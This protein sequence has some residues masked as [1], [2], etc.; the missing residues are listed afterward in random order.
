VCASACQHTVTQREQGEGVEKRTLPVGQR[1]TRVG[2]H[3]P[4]IRRF[5]PIHCTS[6]SGP[7]GGRGWSGRTPR[8]PG[9]P[10]GCPAG[11]ACTRWAGGP[12]GQGCARGCTPTHARTHNHARTHA[13]PRAH[14]YAHARLCT[15]MHTHAYAHIGTHAHTRTHTHGMGHRVC[16]ENKECMCVCVRVCV[17]ERGR[18]HHTV[19]QYR[20]AVWRHAPDAVRQKCRPQVS[21]PA[22]PAGRPPQPRSRRR[23]EAWARARQRCRRSRNKHAHLLFP[24]TSDTHTILS[25]TIHTH[26]RTYM[27]R[28]KMSRGYKGTGVQGGARAD[29]EG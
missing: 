14:A 1:I 7:W 29:V 8:T 6:H 23:R 27:R 19:K 20:G 16:L 12:W 17:S 18:L 24:Y 11:T 25:H 13:R 2:A 26:S 4:R 9:C 10:G 15:H 22:G 28:Y 5:F 21:G 3:N